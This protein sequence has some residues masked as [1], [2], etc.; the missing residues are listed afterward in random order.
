MKGNG[1]DNTWKGLNFYVEGDIIYGRDA[2]IGSLSHFIFNNVQ[3]VI[4]GRSG[5][6]KSSIVRAGIFP[7]ARRLGKT[8][9]L[10]RLKHDDGEPYVEQIRKA[11]IASGIILTERCAAVSGRE[12]LW[13]FIHRHDFEDSKSGQPVTPLLVFDQFEEIFTLQTDEKTRRAFF[14]ELADLFNDVKPYYIVEHEEKERSSATSKSVKNISAGG[15]KNININISLPKVENNNQGKRDYKKSPDYHIVFSLREDFLSSLENYAFNIPAMKNNRFALLPINEEQAAEIITKPVPGLIDKNVA[16]FIIQKIT[17]K[18]DFELDGSPKIE[19]DSAILSLYL[20]RLFEK[21]KSEGKVNINSELVETYSSNIIEDYY[22]DAIKE[23]PAQSVE[24]LEDTLINSE[25]RRDNRDKTTVLEQSG[26]TE[27]ELHSLINETKLLRQFSYGGY[28]R[29]EF[30]HDVIAPVVVRHR[31]QRLAMKNQKKMRRRN[32]LLTI[33]IAVLAIMLAV[34]AFS[35]FTTRGNSYDYNLKVE[36]DST[37]NAGEDWRVKIFMIDGKDTILNKTV[38]KLNAN[39][40]LHLEKP[41]SDELIIDVDLK[42]GS[43]RFKVDNINKDL[44]NGNDISIL[45]TQRYKRKVIEGVVKSDVGS[46]TA[47]G[48]ALIIIDD[49]VTKTDYRGRFKLNVDERYAENLIRIIKKGYNFYEGEIDPSGVY[50]IKFAGDFNFYDNAAAIEKKVLDSPG[51]ISLSGK[52]TDDSGASGMTHTELAVIEGEII[53]FCYY[54]ATRKNARNRF[55]SYFLISGTLD[56]RNGTFW[57]KL[58][59]SVNN[60][61]MY[62][63]TVKDGVWRGEDY[64]KDVRISH[65]ELTETSSPA[66]RRPLSTRGMQ[67]RT[68]EP[69][70]RRALPSDIVNEVNKH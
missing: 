23:L 48:N 29:V 24:W 14:N 34:L 66:N 5:I 60:E 56:E 2:E 46:K 37:I 11:I 17:G 51:R 6:G 33:C 31:Q 35:F 69:R 55:D 61:E 28:L 25:G 64:D 8:P 20:S 1:H 16:K 40:N 67:P 49:Q 21:M 58:V 43:D 42:T 54:D 15:F 63:G 13:E 4:Y 10:V 36:A 65:F 39:V 44:G 52:F 19:V 26:L 3:T 62:S 47:V 38:D 7:R 70:T 57:I 22:S 32:L 50:R 12:S 45:L 9:V 68:S 59:D 18:V 30:I 41:L 53:G 27:P